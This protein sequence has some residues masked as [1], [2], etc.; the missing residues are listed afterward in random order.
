MPDESGNYKT[1]PPHELVLS[2]INKRNFLYRFPL[3]G[4]TGVSACDPLPDNYAD[5]CNQVLAFSNGGDEF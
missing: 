3:H 1:T 4:G 5:L 2:C